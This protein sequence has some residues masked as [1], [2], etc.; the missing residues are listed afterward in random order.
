MYR[1]N[2]NRTLGS[3]I[4][5]LRHVLKERVGPWREGL[6]L[7]TG[8]IGRVLS[9]KD[10]IQLRLQL[11]KGESLRVCSLIE[12]NCFNTEKLLLIQSNGQDVHLKMPVN[13]AVN[14]DG[15]V[16]E[17]MKN[18]GVRG[19]CIL[20]HN[21]RE[22][23]KPSNMWQCWSPFEKTLPDHYMEAWFQWRLQDVGDVRIGRHLP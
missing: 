12:S 15:T 8:T 18:S 19:S 13:L 4:F 10:S 11:K 6:L 16:F 9:R 20:L 23:L 2:R 3:T 22:K 1:W 7:C 21:F 17:S 14:P 5:L